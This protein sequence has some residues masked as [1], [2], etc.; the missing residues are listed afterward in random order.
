MALLGGCLQARAKRVPMAVHTAIFSVFYV[1]F[2]L[3]RMDAP[4]RQP[5]QTVV[6]FASTSA[7]DVIPSKQ[8]S[9]D[10]FTKVNQKICF[11]CSG[12][13]KRDFI[14]KGNI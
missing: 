8:N 14:Q 2:R 12:Y 13:K 1:L 6:D 11:I 7:M 4:E 3:Q 10:S 5:V 9:I